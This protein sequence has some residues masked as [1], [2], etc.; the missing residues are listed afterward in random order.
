MDMVGEL[1]LNSLMADEIQ[2]PQWIN[3]ASMLLF[4]MGPS[5]SGETPLSLSDSFSLPDSCRTRS[6][7]IL[8]RSKNPTTTICIPPKQMCVFFSFFFMISHGLHLFTCYV[9]KSFQQGASII[10]PAKV[11]LFLF[12]KR[13]KRISWCSTSPFAS[14]FYAHN[15]STW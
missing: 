3:F 8:S 10:F 1:P 14:P 4:I 5:A 12:L 11:F 6:F 2:I 15:F 7:T 13:R 9:L